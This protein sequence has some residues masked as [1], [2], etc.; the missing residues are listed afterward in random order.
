ME[1]NIVKVK[2]ICTEILFHSVDE[3]LRS[4]SENSKYKVASPLF[5]INDFQ[6]E[7][8]VVAVVGIYH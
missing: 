3:K 6:N 8:D 1:S 2:F 4:D 5:S 7:Y